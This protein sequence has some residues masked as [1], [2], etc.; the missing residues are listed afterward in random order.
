MKNNQSGQGL[1][2]YGLMLGLMSILVI[3]LGL[4]IFP[5]VRGIYRE[6]L[7]PDTLGES[8]AALSSS[9]Y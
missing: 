6:A 9:L 2:E 5:E 4:Y 8:Q 3:A 1:I 7:T